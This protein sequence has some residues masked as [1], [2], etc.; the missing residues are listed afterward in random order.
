[1]RT[2]TLAIFAIVSNIVFLLPLSG[3]ELPKDN[4]SQ[5]VVAEGVGA[6]PDEALKDAFRNAVRQVVGAVI[7][8]ETIV[9]ND[10]L[11][12][13]K[14][15]T[16]S[17][18]FIKKYDEIDGSKKKSGGLHR[19]SIK[20]EV[21]KKSLLAK[22]QSSNVVMKSV[23][24]NGLFAQTVTKLDSEKDA[25]AILEKQFKGFPQSCLTAS[26]VGEPKVI[27]KDSENATIEIMVQLEPNMIAFRDFSKNLR[28]IL[29][30]MT[31]EKGEFE[32]ICKPTTG[33]AYTFAMWKLSNPPPP[34]VS[35]FA[36]ASYGSWYSVIA[37]N[38]WIP[39]KFIKTTKP[40]AEEKKIV[41]SIGTN[42]SKAGERID[43]VAYRIDPSLSQSLNDVVNKKG[44]FSVALFEENGEKITA[45]EMKLHQPL[46]LQ[47]GSSKNHAH[48]F[49]LCPTFFPMIQPGAI[50]GHTPLM[51]VPFRFKLSLDELKALSDI[52]VEVQF[53]D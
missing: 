10:E 21:E 38:K 49:Y 47:I 43:F 35:E 12:N 13:D 18:G 17:D 29:D 52:K 9:K 28:S 34:S 42:R 14:V 50:L 37:A 25:I 2:W 1:M 20:A 45:K 24:G 7:D 32:V 6:S 15:L 39:S 46:L 23:D 26:V 41:L 48:S 44:I 19:V 53:E 3:Q 33:F 36:T 4:G 30:K 8:A 40:Q 5:I 51:K 31:R 11:I 16:Y 22:L 27:E